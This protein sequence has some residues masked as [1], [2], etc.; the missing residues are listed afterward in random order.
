MSFYSW[1]KLQLI[2]YSD[3]RQR[4]GETE[5]S[6]S[7][8][9]LL[10]GKVRLAGIQSRC[11]RRTLFASKNDKRKYVGLLVIKTFVNLVKAV[12][13]DGVLE[14]YQNNQYHK[15]AVQR[16]AL[17]ISTGPLARRT[18]QTAGPV[19]AST[20]YL[21][22]ARTGHLD[23][24]RATRFQIVVARTMTN[25]SIYRGTFR[26]G[27]RPTSRQFSRCPFATARRQRDASLSQACQSNT[28]TSV[29]RSRR[30][31][32]FN[33]NIREGA[34]SGTHPGTFLREAHGMVSSKQF[35]VVVG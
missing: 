23:I 21:S 29:F 35:C 1:E 32:Y 5:K 2:H 14:N 4:K 7:L 3:H 30:T 28:L 19:R 18:F 24:C 20:C 16:A 15:Y 8:S 13:K 27:A 33:A 12:G 34:P 9:A 25:H 31:R 10:A 22:L 6:V 26:A 11:W 17:D